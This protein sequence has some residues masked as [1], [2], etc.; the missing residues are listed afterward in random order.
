MD[1][2]PKPEASGNDWKSRAK[3][4]IE[5]EKYVKFDDGT[6]R[7]VTF[8]EEPYE[9]TFRAKDGK[10]K[11]SLE[12]PVEIKGVKKIMSVTSKRLLKKLI[13]QD[14]KTPLIGRTL[15]IRAIGDGTMRDWIVKEEF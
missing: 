9:R 6:E 12:F 10:N 7:T 1:N 8:V 15:Y 5:S 2:Q 4:S 13:A 11:P 14:D 3:D